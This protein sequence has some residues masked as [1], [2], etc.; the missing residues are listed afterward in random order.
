MAASLRIV[1][2]AGEASGDQLG[3]GLIRSALAMNPGLEFVGIAGPAMRE[4]GCVP[5]FHTE[6]LSVMGLAE[7]LRHLPRLRHIRNAFTTQGRK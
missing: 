3:A 5:W 2:A 4:A 1:I 7:I 6:D